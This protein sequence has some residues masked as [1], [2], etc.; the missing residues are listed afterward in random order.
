MGNSV[1]WFG[2][3]IFGSGVIKNELAK[4]ESAGTYTW[5]GSGT[6]LDLRIESSVHAIEP[7]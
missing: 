6:E 3:A 4:G 1:D 2:L 7:E 5:L